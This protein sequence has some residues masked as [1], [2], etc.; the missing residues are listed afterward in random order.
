M[1]SFLE[2]YTL[3][4]SD[5]L[6]I[7]IRPSAD[8]LIFINWDL[9]WNKEISSE[10]NLLVIR[11]NLVYRTKW[12]EGAWHQNTLSGAESKVVS[13]IERE[14]MLDDKCFDLRAYQNQ[15]SDI[16]APMMNASLTHTTFEIM[17]W[18]GYEVLHSAEVDFFCIDEF[19]NL[20]EIPFN[21]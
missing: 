14:Q 7:R 19:G 4:D 3:H 21:K 16:E 12:L 2:R 9:H 5:L 8:M 11:F 18:G 17:N 6:E 13:E 1:P 20:G 10:F 15:R